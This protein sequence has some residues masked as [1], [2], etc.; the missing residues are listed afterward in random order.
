[1]ISL[2]PVSA[3]IAVSINTSVFQS[4]IAH[5]AAAGG[6]VIERSDI[7][8]I[9]RVGGTVVLLDLHAAALSFARATSQIYPR[10]E[11]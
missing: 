8:H 5:G 7:I 10:E 4:G 11:L 3:G 1:L 2:V 9:G 6:V